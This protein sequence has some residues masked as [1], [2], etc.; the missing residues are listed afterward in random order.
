MGVKRKGPCTLCTVSCSTAPGTEELRAVMVKPTFAVFIGPAISL[1]PCA[2]FTSVKLLFP[3]PE[4]VAPWNVNVNGP[5]AETASVMPTQLRTGAFA[6]HA[7]GSYYQ[8]LVFTDDHHFDCTGFALRY[9]GVAT[10][11]KNNAPALYFDFNSRLCFESS[12]ERN[13]D[14]SLAF[15]SSA[16][17]I[18]DPYID[19]LLWVIVRVSPNHNRYGT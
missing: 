11:R 16:I 8:L 2:R 1:R 4:Y 14:F 6:T 12:G 19:S 3:E 7:G 15:R 9:W 18:F 5:S 17:G 13:F 10:W